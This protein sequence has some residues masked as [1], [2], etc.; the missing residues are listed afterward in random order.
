MMVGSALMV[1]F[2]RRHGRSDLD[3]VRVL[4]AAIN[5]R[6]ATLLLAAP[7]AVEGD[8]A[9]LVGQ[10]TVVALHGFH[11]ASGAQAHDVELQRRLWTV[12][13]ELTGVVA[14]LG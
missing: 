7:E 3:G 12:S 4:T 9:D 6:L 1:C 2:S 5:Y 11:P 8:L 10:L 14:P 13:D